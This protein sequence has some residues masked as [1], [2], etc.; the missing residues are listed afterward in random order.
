MQIAAY[1]S[2]GTPGKPNEDYFLIDST[3]AIVLDGATAR[4]DTG[5]THG[6]A[7]YAANLGNALKLR[8]HQGLALKKSLCLAIEEV[9]DLHRG[10][11]DLT[12]PGT[13]SAAVA[14]ISFVQSEIQWLLLGDATILLKR[15]QGTVTK[16][17]QRG[18]FPV[19]PEQQ[20]ANK[21]LI[22]DPRKD[23]AL[24]AMKRA[25]LATRNTPAGFWVAAADSSIAEHALVGTF[26]TADVDAVGVMSDG[27]ARVVDLFHLLSWEE[28]VKIA[29]S[30]GPAAIV[31]T[32]RETEESDP[33]GER[34]PRNKKSDDAT[35]IVC[36]P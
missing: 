10:T 22:G 36:R 19:P 26:S 15:S 12:H 25:E 30:E 13:P 29:I 17:D 5:C 4:T 11:C 7:W 9:A 32:V 20:E 31:N 35:L 3:T 8:V 14:L 2:P 16:S 21:Y 18:R 1:T 28:A 27:A 34:W 23:S 33:L 24:Q 6:A